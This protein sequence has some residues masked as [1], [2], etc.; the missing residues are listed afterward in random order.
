MSAVKRE[1]AY[2]KVKQDTDIVLACQKGRSLAAQADLSGDEQTLVAI[3]IAEVARNILQ[4]AGHGEITLELVQKDNKYG[5]S[6]VAH[7]NGP[8]IPDVGK[9]L[10]DGYSTGH[11]LG[12]GLPGAKRLMDDF[13]ITSQV[14]RGTTVTM[15][16]WKR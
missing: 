7:D 11:G 9:A 12:M 15:R 13:G 16:K 8:G 10:Q 4:H 5:V 3:A 2:I 1:P 14:G 6:I